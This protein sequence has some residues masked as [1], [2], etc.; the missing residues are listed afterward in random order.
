MK[1]HTVVMRLSAEHSIMDPH[2][3]A[4]TVGQLLPTQGTALGKFQGYK[5]VKY[6]AKVLRRK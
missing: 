2:L 5:D 4:I 1:E 6:I 3:S